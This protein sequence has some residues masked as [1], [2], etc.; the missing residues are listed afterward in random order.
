MNPDMT[1]ERAIRRLT[2]R[3]RR[4]GVSFDE[5]SKQMVEWLSACAVFKEE[6]NE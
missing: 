4:V 1:M 5:L 3:M 6:T 2:C